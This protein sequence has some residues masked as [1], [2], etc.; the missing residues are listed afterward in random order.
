MTRVA[1]PPGKEPDDDM[2][3]PHDR[4]APFPLGDYLTICDPCADGGEQPCLRRDFK[5]ADDEA[6]RGQRAFAKMVRQSVTVGMGA[7]LIGLGQFLLPERV[8]KFLGPWFFWAEVFYTVCALGYV[9]YALIMGT[10]ERW[11]GERFKAE[12]LRLLKFRVLIDPRLWLAKADP[13]GRSDPLALW[14]DRIETGR[15]QIANQPDKLLDAVTVSD[16]LPD[17]PATEDCRAVDASALERLLKYYR[18]K[19]LDFQ[20]DYFASKTRKEGSFLD[21]NLLPPIFFFVGIALALGSFLLELATKDA[22]TERSHFFATLLVVG[23][24]AVP[25]M[26]SALRTRRSAHEVARNLARSHARHASLTEIRDSLSRATSRPQNEWDQALIFGYLYA[27]EGVLAGDQHEWIRLMRE[28][29]W[30]G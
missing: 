4:G 24:F 9:L 26:W 25:L 17:L 27:C 1:T 5:D 11:L 19:R 8:S 22:E 18:R 23:S 30:Y 3:D 20:L 21:H 28:A 7:L 10:Q 6:I 12:R 15:R 2:H 16:A 29:D 13:S 14:R